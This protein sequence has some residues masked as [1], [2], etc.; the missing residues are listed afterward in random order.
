MFKAMNNTDWADWGDVAPTLNPEQEED[1]GGEWTISE[2][3]L[4]MSCHCPFS[5]SRLGSLVAS[6]SY[7]GEQGKAI[8]SAVHIAS[9]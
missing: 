3:D 8:T 1:I 9:K 6:A 4:Y 7:V 2:N 5:V